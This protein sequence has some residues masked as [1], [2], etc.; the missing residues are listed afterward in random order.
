MKVNFKMN[1]LSCQNIG[2]ACS[3][4]TRAV[5]LSI[6]LNAGLHLSAQIT[7]STDCSD[8]PIFDTS[9]TENQ[10]RAELI[11]QMGDEFIEKVSDQTRCQ[12]PLVNN[13]GG[14][15]GGGAGGGGSTSIVQSPNKLPDGQKSVELDSSL[16]TL[17]SASVETSGEGLGNGREE[18]VLLKADADAQQIS[19]LRDEIAKTDDP[20]LK[21]FF[22]DRIKELQK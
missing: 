19:Q 8:A 4:L 14:G 9:Q 22:E 6:I 5:A 12:D 11:A 7:N 17:N 20:E 1:S 21:K 2:R 15:G 10:T 18:L 3:A 16:S 13:N